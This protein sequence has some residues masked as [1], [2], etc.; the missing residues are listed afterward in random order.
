MACGDY[1]HSDTSTAHIQAKVEACI[2]QGISTFDQADI[3]GGYMAE[4]LLATLRKHP[5]T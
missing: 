3:Y 5:I 2:E 4:G 1:R